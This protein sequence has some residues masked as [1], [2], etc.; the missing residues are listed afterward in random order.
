MHLKSKL[1][2]ILLLLNSY[3]YGI[4]PEVTTK[5]SDVLFKQVQAEI[6][7]N[8]RRLNQNKSHLPLQFFT[9]KIKKIDTLFSVAS[10]FNLPYDSIASLNKIDNQLFFKAFKTIMIPSCSGLFTDSRT[11]DKAEII[12]IDEIKYYFTPGQRFTGDKRLNFLITPFRSPLSD[13]IVTSG[14]GLRENPFT[15]KNEFHSGLDLKATY[16]S[17]IFT[18]YD[19]I[20]SNIGYSDFYGN[21]LIILHPNGYSSHYYHLEK[22]LIAEKI[23]VNKGDYVAQT[24]NSG[25]STGPH[26]HFEIH[27]DGEPVNPSILLGDV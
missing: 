7:E 11:N 3:L 27:L 5:N 21:Y 23:K 19:G 24:G 4:H 14:F 8:S 9:Y 26:L 17:K 13:M 10:R 25:K 15:K 20:I 2:I 18:P 16:G 6:T 12:K 22:I 1:I